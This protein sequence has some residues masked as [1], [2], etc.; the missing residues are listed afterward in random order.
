VGVCGGCFGGR[1]G[2]GGVGIGCLVC[3]AGPASP[4]SLL[5]E[6]CLRV[7]LLR[8]YGACSR[9]PFPSA[10]LSDSSSRDL[11]FRRKTARVRSLAQ[12]PPATGKVESTPHK[13]ISSGGPK[14][15]PPSGSSKE[16][17]PNRRRICFTDRKIA[18]GAT[19]GEEE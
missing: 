19:E 6:L 10:S 4:P 18:G 14:G 2:G 8:P 11:C 17:P 1:W 5:P 12:G 9:R 7:A 13:R 16:R 3:V 15:G